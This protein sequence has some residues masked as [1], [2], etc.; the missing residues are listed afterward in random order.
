MGKVFADIRDAWE[1]RQGRAPAL[2][3]AADALAPVI[4]TKVSSVG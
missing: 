4:E 2:E 3:P 1:R